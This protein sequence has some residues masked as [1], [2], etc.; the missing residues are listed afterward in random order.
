MLKSSK[1][2]PDESATRFEPILRPRIARTWLQIETERFVSQKLTRR[3]TQA[4]LASLAR[5]LRMLF[6]HSASQKTTVSMAHWL[7]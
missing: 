6:D 2:S 4:A 5:Y 3:D 1:G 7:T